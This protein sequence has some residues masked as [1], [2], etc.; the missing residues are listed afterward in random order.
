M[1]TNTAFLDGENIVNRKL[2]KPVLK[3]AF[4]L[5]LSYIIKFLKFNT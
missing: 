1:G 3:R 4:L 2:K 5:V